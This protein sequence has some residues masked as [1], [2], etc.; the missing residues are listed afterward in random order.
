MNL[1][2]EHKTKKKKNNSSFNLDDDTPWGEERNDDEGS[3]KKVYALQKDMIQMNFKNMH[4]ETKGNELWCTKCKK[5]GHTK[6]SYLK[7]QFCEIF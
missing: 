1:E 3:R 2:N 4:K 5:E 6:G 7:D